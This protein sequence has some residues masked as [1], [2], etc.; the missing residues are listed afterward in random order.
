MRNIENSPWLEKPKLVEIK[1]TKVDKKRLSEF[2]MNLSL[3]P[4][5]PQA[6]KGGKGKKG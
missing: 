5:T 1:A 4:L 6:D 2:T 3:K